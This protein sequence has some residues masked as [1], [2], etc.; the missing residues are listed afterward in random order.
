MSRIISENENPITLTLGQVREKIREIVDKVIRPNADRIDRSKEFPS[1]NIAVLAKEGF[2][3]IL[4]PE[5]LEGLGLNYSAFAIVVQEIAKAC[6]STALIYTMHVEAAR[7]I[8]SHGNE[9]QWERWLKPIRSGKFG[10]TST[11]EGA[12]GGHYWYN[13]SEAVRT[14]DGYIINAQKSFT[15]SSGFA[16]FYV[17]QTK[18]PNAKSPDD[19]TYFI[20]DGHQ[21]GIEAGEW[22]ALGVRGN[23]SSSLTLRNVFVDKK[24]RLGEE[25]EGKEIVQNGIAYLIGLGATWTGT[26][27]G[28]LDE[29]LAY[30]K[31]KVHQD[32]N[33][34]LSD[35]QVIRSQLAKAKILKDSL[36]A[37]QKDLA[38][39]LDEWLESGEKYAP[40][41]LKN[42]LLE[43]K[44]LASD[45]ANEIAQ[46]GL[47]ISGG[48][49]Y[50]EGIL[51]RLYR[52]ARAG[53]AMGPSNHIAREMIGK[54]LLD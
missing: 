6:P 5:K 46:I 22:A 35:Y 33:K 12:T 7:T 14:D 29:T 20:V 50:R 13:I 52:D 41:E 54:N 47:D 27:I 19:I 3:S 32:V 4:L 36:Q 10:T 48:F 44:V 45:A 51:E 38:S 39:Q 9:D 30:A 8:Y 17:F 25:G 2:N 15:T 1:E 23:H 28:I 37:W 31:R 40:E 11:S 43:F 34:A 16:D 18:T 21:E 42:S 49:G 53:I 24:D 26:A